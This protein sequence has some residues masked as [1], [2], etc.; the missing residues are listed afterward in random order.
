MPIPIPIP[1]LL[2]PAIT[3]QIQIET[4]CDHESNLVPSSLFPVFVTIPEPAVKQKA[5]LVLATAPVK[6]FRN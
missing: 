6:S 2:Y 5:S 1:I 4:D 3:P